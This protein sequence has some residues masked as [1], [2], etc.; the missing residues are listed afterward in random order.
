MSVTWRDVAR[1]DFEDAVKSKLLWG[2]M[3]GF[4][5]L[6]G[7]L[8]IVGYVG[9]GDDVDMV[10]GMANS[11]QLI[12]FFVPLLALIA[13]YMAI[14]GE[15]E[16]GSLRVLM[17]Y[18]FS[19]G[20]V[21]AG[22]FAGRTAVVVTA[23]L[24]GLG[25]LAVL[26]I[27]LAGTLPA[28]ELAAFLALTLVLAVT[29]TGVAVGISS[30]TA[31]RGRALALVVVVFFLLLVLWEP[32]AVGIYYLVNGTRPG[33]EVESWY[34]FIYQANPIGA[35]RFALAETL[36]SYVW[37]LVQFGLE[38]ISFTEVEPDDRLLDSRTG[39]DIPFYLQPWFSVVTFLVWTVAPIAIGYRRFRS[40]DLD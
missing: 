37:P 5:G 19:R 20:D 2:L 4:V 1:K 24:V 26:N 15:R 25:V 10:E 17:A 14:V 21:V 39:G 29:F 40:A 35:Y 38:D 9:G 33:L 31:T 18:P 7:L 13:G 3:A 36:D 8:T 30:M 16:S 28:V 6:L 34:L 22:K 11:G 32:I 27:A 23:T 12:S